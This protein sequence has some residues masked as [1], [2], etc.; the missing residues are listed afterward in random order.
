VPTHSP[1][2]VAETVRRAGLVLHE[3]EKFLRSH[4]PDHAAPEVPAG[5]EVSVTRGD[6]IEVHVTRDGV[7]AASG[8]IA[9]VGSDAVPQAV[10]T[11]HEGLAG[12]VLGV[13]AQQAVT[14][15]AT[16]G[17]VSTA[18]EVRYRELGW[19]TVSDVVIASN[20]KGEA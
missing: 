15:G 20:T 13:L 8:S 7:A 6:L 11:A 10:E 5:F 14:A 9:V 17:F 16:T 3:P 1:D 4:L 19:E 18:D 2:E 12:V